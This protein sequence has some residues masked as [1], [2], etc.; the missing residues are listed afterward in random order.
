MDPR[1]AAT[2]A[3]AAAAAAV[4]GAAHDEP[5]DLTLYERFMRLRA[6]KASP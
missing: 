4:A 2:T 5:E 6:C 1:A 3:T